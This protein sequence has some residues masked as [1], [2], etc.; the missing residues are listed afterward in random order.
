MIVDLGIFHD[1]KSARGL[2]AERH[3]KYL[4]ALRFA[5][6]CLGAHSQLRHS[7]LR[8]QPV[9]NLLRNFRR[10]LIRN[11]KTELTLISPST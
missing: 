11:R 1:R 5:G 6:P 9:G 3:I 10:R 4:I 2:D 7:E 8:P